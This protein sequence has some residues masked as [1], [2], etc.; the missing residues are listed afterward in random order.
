MGF[1][2]TIILSSGFGPAMAQAQ[3]PTPPSQSYECPANARCSISC[4]VDGDKVVQTGS[5][6]T[7]NITQLT[8]NNYL[9]E[10]VEQGG[11]VQFAYLAGAKVV[12]T[13]EGVMKA[14]SQ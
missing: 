9:V 7:I 10:L 1:L 3:R 4:T 12:C 6:K 5:P 11:H 14:G 2:T 13:L 8:R